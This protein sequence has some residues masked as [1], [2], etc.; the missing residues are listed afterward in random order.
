VLACALAGCAYVSTPVGASVERRLLAQKLTD[1]EFGGQVTDAGK[2][3]RFAVFEGSIPVAPVTVPMIETYHDLPGISVRLNG[4]RAVPML[5]DTGAQLCI[6]DAESVLAGGGRPYVPTRIHVSVTGIGGNEEAWL[7]RF[8]HADIGGIELREFTTLVRRQKTVARFGLLP[9]RTMAINLMGC[10]V[11][12]AFNHVTFDY[13]AHRFVFSG[14]TA[15]Q[16]SHRARA[17][18]LTTRGQLLYVPLQIG[19]RTVQ[20]MVDTGA[21]DQIFLNTK[22]VAKLRLT[23]LAQSGGYYRAVGLGGETAGRQ[24]RQSLVF[25]GEVPVRDVVVDTADSD[26]W[27]ARIGTELLS[28]WRV[29]FDFQRR[30]LWLE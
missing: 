23:N 16:P 10:P 25:M 28:R 5:A 4:R 14:H 17:V 29:T 8:A 30:V 27:D 19:G 13:P 20:A 18:P 22:T 9:L 3:I 7:A 24:F 15:F 26:A 11:F 21:K 12:L 2:S 6:L 1:R